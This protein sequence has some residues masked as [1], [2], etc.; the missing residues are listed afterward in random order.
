MPITHVYRGMLPIG[1]QIYL[2]VATGYQIMVTAVS[3]GRFDVMIATADPI[4]RV[5]VIPETAEVSAMIRP[6]RAIRFRDTDRDTEE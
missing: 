5:T 6:A 3:D 4:E 1:H 2:D